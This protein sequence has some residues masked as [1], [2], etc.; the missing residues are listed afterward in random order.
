[1]NKNKPYSIF[2]LFIKYCKYFYLAKTKHGVHSPFLYNFVTKAL[3]KRLD[4]KQFK[5]IEIH[6]SAAKKDKS[7]IEVHDFG[8]KQGIYNTTISKI[9]N[10]SVKNKRNSKLLFKIFNF[11]KPQNCI[12]LGTSLGISSLY[13]S[14]AA[15]NCKIISME[16]SINISKYAKELHL[17][18]KTRNITVVSANINDELPNILIEQQYISSAFIDANHTKEATIKYFEEFL[19]FVNET[20]FLVFDDIHWSKDMEEAWSVI[21]KNEKVSISVDLF[22]F[23]IVF[24]REGIEKQNFILR[25]F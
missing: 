4:N 11:F 1:M 23:G 13:I 2:V 18:S 9:A 22:F 10:N 5:E 21:I 16:G 3:N 6:R 17:K 19:P 24:F 15:P 8:A 20:S 25:H 12:E 7:I 14:K